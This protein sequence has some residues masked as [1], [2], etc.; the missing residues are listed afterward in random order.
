MLTSFFCA[1]TRD[2]FFFVSQLRQKGN[3]FGKGGKRETEESGFQGLLF[4]QEVVSLEALDLGDIPFPPKS[5][6]RCKIPPDE[7]RGPLKLEQA[8]RAGGTQR[9]RDTQVGVAGELRRPDQLDQCPSAYRWGSC[10]PFFNWLPQKTKPLYYSC[11][12]CHLGENGVREKRWEPGM[13]GKSTQ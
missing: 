4:L 12:V 10:T 8:V 6:V 9:V 7:Q 1:V 3:I 5:Q 2:A 11:I 13:V